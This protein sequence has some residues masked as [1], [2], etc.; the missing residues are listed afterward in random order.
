[1]LAMQM[2][3]Q[4][5]TGFAWRLALYGTETRMFQVKKHWKDRPLAE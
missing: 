1:M 3:N 5:D 2:A 4:V